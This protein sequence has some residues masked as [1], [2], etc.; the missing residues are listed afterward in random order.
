MQRKQT[1][2]IIIATGLGNKEKEINPLTPLGTTTI[3]KRMVLTFQL[4]KVS[5]IIIITGFDGLSVE[6]HLANYGVVFFRVENYNKFNFQSTIGP[7]LKYAIEKSEQIFIA[8]VEYPLCMTKTLKKM[9]YTEGKVCIPYINQRYGYPFLVSREMMANQLETNQEFSDWD[10]FIKENAFQ[11]NLV[12]VEDK[13]V[14]CSIDNLEQCNEIVEEHNQQMLH[15]YVRVD[16]DY[17][18]RIFDPKT[19]ILLMQ[20]KDTQSVK[21]ACERISLSIGKAWEI[22]NILEDALG[23]K[24]VHRRQGGKRGGKTRLTLEGEDYLERY[25]LLEKKVQ[26][27]ANDEFERI[28]PQDIS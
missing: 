20:I 11:A 23:Y 22:I 5:P 16:I 3:V 24:V 15:P 4:A 13:G 2:G 27:F 1:A 17:V 9:I 14:I 10:T 26:E 18:T 6:R 7:A 8:P 25:Q 28:F 12:D 19:K 21:K